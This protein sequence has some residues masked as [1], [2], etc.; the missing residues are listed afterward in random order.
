ME[1]RRVA[2]TPRFIVAVLV[3]GVV[4]APGLRAQEVEPLPDGATDEGPRVGVL[5]GMRAE[6]LGLVSPGASVDLVLDSPNRP[7]WLSVQLLAQMIRWNVQYDPLSRR[8][9]IYVGRVRLGLG[10]RRGPRIYALAEKG[11]GV[12]MTE[13][14][15][16]RGRTY[17]LTGVGLGV[18]LAGERFTTSFEL[19]IGEANRSS[20]SL[21]GGLGVSLQYRLPRP[22][23]G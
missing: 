9:H 19:V 22:G 20:W 4:P 6:L 11:I 15:S 17:N 5:V 18:G 23:Q 3:A 14:A 12:I 16:W 8:D 2:L 21:Y 7:I 10:R 13:P 1:P